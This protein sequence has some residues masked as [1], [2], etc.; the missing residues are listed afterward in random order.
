MRPSSENRAAAGH[1]QRTV[2]KGERTSLGLAAIAMIPGRVV[3]YREQARRW[4][5]VAEKEIDPKL[6]E[7]A[8]KVARSYELKAEHEEGPRK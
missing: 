3:F 7:E 5:A 6:K 8:L 2:V 4:H 1:Q